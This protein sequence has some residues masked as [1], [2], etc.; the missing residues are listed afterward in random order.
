MSV[1]CIDRPPILR[2]FIHS[3]LFDS[4]LFSDPIAQLAGDKEISRLFNSVKFHPDFRLRSAHKKF[5]QESA[6]RTMAAIRT[7][8]HASFALKKAVKEL[9][10][11][12]L[13]ALIS[14]GH[15]KFKDSYNLVSAIYDFAD[16]G[17]F[18]SLKR[19]YGRL[20]IPD[21]VHQQVMEKVVA[22]G[23]MLATE[24]LL[25]NHS[26]PLN[27]AKV[28]SSAFKCHCW[29]RMVLLIYPKIPPLQMK[30]ALLKAPASI[31]EESSPQKLDFFLQHTEARNH[32]GEEAWEEIVGNPATK[33]M[34]LFIMD[35]KNQI[36]I[37][38]TGFYS[39]TRSCRRN[40]LWDVLKPIL[41]SDR[42]QRDPEFLQNICFLQGSDE[43]FYK[44]LDSEFQLF[45]NSCVFQNSWV[46]SSFLNNAVRHN[47]F[48]ILRTF[49]ESPNA[50]KDN[51]LIRWGWIGGSG[52][53]ICY[54]VRNR[55]LLE[56]SDVCGKAGY[57]DLK[58]RVD[59]ELSRRGRW[60][61]KVFVKLREIFG[62]KNKIQCTHIGGPPLD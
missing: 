45:H 61:T 15:R 23:D 3:N 38:A 10:P 36:P 32:L 24:W 58:S 52:Y 28:L 49:I 60:T 42:A 34:I 29:E 56:I 1:A 19:M 26:L 27:M 18:H 62:T 4:N 54:T 13:N 2:N 59:H 12:L 43:I 21:F 51:Y 22:R 47:C 5:A 55:M 41:S 53:K 48:N 50:I 39:I 17:D 40:K 8:T 9:N 6:D 14:L 11:I 31:L 44:M 37:S 46:A 16:L 30:Q 57:L 25:D 35:P 7:K 33:E 20:K